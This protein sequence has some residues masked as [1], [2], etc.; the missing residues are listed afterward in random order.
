M[1]IVR[2]ARASTLHLMGQNRRYA[3]HYGR[4]LDARTGEWVMRE[5]PMLL[6]AAELQLRQNPPKNFEQPRRV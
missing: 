2:S 3:E 5:D 4:L 6:T 1:S